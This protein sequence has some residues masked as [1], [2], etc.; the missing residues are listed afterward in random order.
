MIIFFYL[1]LIM[2]LAIL[3][4]GE[5]IN[6]SKKYTNHNRDKWTILTIKRKKKKKKPSSRFGLWRNNIICTKLTNETKDKKTGWAQIE[7]RLKKGAYALCYWCM[8]LRL[9]ADFQKTTKT[10]TL[11]AWKVYARMS[12]H[13]CFIPCDMH[14][15][16]T[17]KYSH[18]CIFSLNFT[19][20]WLIISCV[21][22]IGYKWF[23]C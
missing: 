21:C 9:K 5:L 7:V 3:V 14:E 20:S 11:A 15:I 8:H 6:C 17:I 12:T 23:T 13:M 4:V 10:R 1:Y 22:F 16:Y 19:I 18:I 2:L